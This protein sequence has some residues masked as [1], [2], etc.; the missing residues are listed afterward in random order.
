MLMVWQIENKN[1]LAITAME[2]NGRAFARPVA[3]NHGLFRRDHLPCAPLTQQSPQRRRF[4]WLVQ[5]RDIL[6]ASRGAHMRT[7]VC[8]NQ[9]GWNVLPEPAA[10]VAD[11]SDAVAAVEMIIDEKTCNGSA[12]G[13]NGLDRGIRIG[14]RDDLCVPGAQQRLHAVQ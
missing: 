13:A 14:Y 5:H 8:R 4:Q 10:N 1:A 11:R 12:S 6:L 7:S 3:S 9:D 2:W